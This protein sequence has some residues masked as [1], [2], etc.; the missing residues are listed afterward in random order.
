VQGGVTGE[1]SA[2]AAVHVRRPGKGAQ[3]EPGRAAPPAGPNG[4]ERAPGLVG[5]V[6]EELIVVVAVSRGR[7]RPC[8]ATGQHHAAGALVG[9]I[10]G[11]NGRADEVRLPAAAVLHA[12]LVTDNE[13]VKQGQSLA[14]GQRAG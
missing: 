14:W 12:F 10:E 2:M 5:T 1:G 3:R 4:G 6:A 7:F 9:R 8:A 11:G 13:V